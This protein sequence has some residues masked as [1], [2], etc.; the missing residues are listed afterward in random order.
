RGR[1]GVREIREEKTAPS[2]RTAMTKAGKKRS[3]VERRALLG[4]AA[5]GG[6]AL[7]APV[8]A[9]A[10]RAQAKPIKLGYVS[11]QTGPL[12]AF[13]EADNFVL[14][15]FRQAMASGISIGNQKRPVEVI[16][17]DSQSN[18]NRV[19]EGSKELNV[20]D[21]VDPILAATRPE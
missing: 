19:A 13:P 1:R 14:G 16:V 8:G 12:A 3:G 20:R 6:M 18:P 15:Q 2:G 17:K 9:P 11:P 7:A 10:V 5:A 21:K 4:R